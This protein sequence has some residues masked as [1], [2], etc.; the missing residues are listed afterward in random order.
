MVRGRTTG[1]TEAAG[2][3]L[4]DGL[5]AEFATAAAAAASAAS[6]ICAAEAATS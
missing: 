4:A 1:F 6:A 2:A 3:I 5:S